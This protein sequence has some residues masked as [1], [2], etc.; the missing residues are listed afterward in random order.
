MDEIVSAY[1]DNVV[2]AY[3]VKVVS[4]EG[5]SG[6]IVFSIGI[7]LNGKIKGVKI[8]DS[9]ETPGLGSKINEEVIVEG[10]KKYWG[11]IW[12]GRNKDY[13]FN[14]S[15]DAFAGA[16]VSPM[17]IYNEIIKTLNIYSE[18]KNGKHNPIENSY[19]KISIEEGEM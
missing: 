19:E 16:T 15:V 5:Y 2:D 4:K 10:E 1:K 17:A 14:K 18:I 12:I 8:I 3:V 11:D 6:D 9:K 7:D 13:K